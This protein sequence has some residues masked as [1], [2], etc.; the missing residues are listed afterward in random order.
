MLSEAAHMGY[1]AGSALGSFSANMEANALQAGV[2]QQSDLDLLNSVGATDQD[3]ANLMAGIVTLQ[4]LYAQYGIT[5][6]PAATPATGA[7][8]PSASAAPVGQ[9]PPG[10]TIL[11]TA[12][13]NAAEGFVTASAVISDIASQLAAHQMS[14][15]SNSVQNSGL[16]SLGN[17]TMTILDS[18]GHQYTSDIQSILDSLLN[19]YT[20]NGKVSSSVTVVSPGTSASGLPGSTPNPNPGSVGTWLENN[21]IYIGGAVLALVL[22]NNFTGGKRR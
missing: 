17:F 14:M 20:N 16:V 5:F 9:S 18:V 10:S 15:L 8:T 1:A 3:L 2:C 19:Q 21:A 6:E 7:T 13:F 4:Q 11:Y 22:I 12:S